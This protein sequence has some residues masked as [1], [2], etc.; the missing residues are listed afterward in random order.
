[1]QVK[2]FLY[3]LFISYTKNICTA[4]TDTATFCLIVMET[5]HPQKIC[6]MQI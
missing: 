3:T 4:N 1:M 6:N 2:S 5:V